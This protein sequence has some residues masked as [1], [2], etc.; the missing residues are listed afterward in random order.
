MDSDFTA[1][2]IT[3]FEP[4]LCSKQSNFGCA[5]FWPISSELDSNCWESYWDLDCKSLFVDSIHP[6][7]TSENKMFNQTSEDQSWQGKIPYHLVM[8]NIAMENHHV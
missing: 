6:V 3:D 7:A 2:E 4:W 1:M 8:T 5:R